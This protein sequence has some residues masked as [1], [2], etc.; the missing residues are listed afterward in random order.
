MCFHS[1]QT[2]TATQVENRFKAKIEKPDLFNSK[3][4]YNGFTYPHTPVITNKDSALIQEFHWGLIPNWS[5]DEAIRAYTLNARIE[6][7]K[8]KPSFKGSINNRCLIIA[9]GFYE[10]QWL[11]KKGTKK[12]KY[13]LS[14][15]EEEPFA[16][17]GLYTNWVDINTG[18]IRNTYTIVTTEANAL[19][20]EI[21]NNKKRMPIILTP[22][23]EKLWL[24]GEEIDNF[25]KDEIDL[26]AIAV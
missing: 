11:D 21:H 22:E 18:E 15:K 16:F 17:A 1:K 20:S 10:W 9:D 23:R 7:I 26:L 24:A 14:H 12:Q 13:L 8:E 3:A 25:K 2:K 6:T 5:K 4:I 19:M